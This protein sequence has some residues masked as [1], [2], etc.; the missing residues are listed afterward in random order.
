LRPTFVDQRTLRFVSPHDVARG[1]VAAS[2]RL[3]KGRQLVLAVWL[4]EDLL[5][6][7]L[8]CLPERTIRHYIQCLLSLPLEASMLA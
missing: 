7:F 5:V 1:T 3:C 2:E 6:Q 4:A 8:V